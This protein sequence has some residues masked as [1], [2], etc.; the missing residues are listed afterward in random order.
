MPP[1]SLSFSFFLLTKIKTSECQHLFRLYVDNKNTLP[2]QP[3]F[4]LSFNF[5]LNRFMHKVT[6]IFSYLSACNLPPFSLGFYHLS[7]PQFSLTLFFMPWKSHI[8]CF[9]IP[10]FSLTFWFFL[11]LNFMQ[12]LL[13]LNIYGH[14]LPLYLY[15]SNNFKMSTQFNIKFLIQYFRHFL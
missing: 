14:I 8:Q 4:P 11:Y 7:E 2:S 5:I 9:F 6:A 15:F 10:Q 12:H 1:F 3:P 13:F